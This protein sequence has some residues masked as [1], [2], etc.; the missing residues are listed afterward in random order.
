MATVVLQY[1]GAALGAA[2]GGPLGGVIGRA[3]GAIAGSIID[4][5][6]FGPGG[7]NFQGPRLGDLRVMASEEGAAIPTAMG[8]HADFRPGDLGHQFRG[9]LNHHDAKRVIERRVQNPLDRIFLLRQFRRGAL[10]GRCG[11][12]WPGLG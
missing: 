8:P 2:I 3:A 10:R 9:S 6:L 5:R 4:R 7:Q 11:P 12:H 1:A